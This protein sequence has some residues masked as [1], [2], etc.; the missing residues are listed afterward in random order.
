M[1]DPDCVQCS[2]RD[3]RSFARLL[4]IDEADRDADC[5]GECPATVDRLVGPTLGPTHVPKSTGM[6]R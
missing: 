4:V 6:P 1:D 5:S 3:T 2:I